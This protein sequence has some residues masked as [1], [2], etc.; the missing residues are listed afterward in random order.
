MIIHYSIA[1]ELGRQRQCQIAADVAAS[2]RYRAIRRR[3]WWA[4]TE[5][6]R[7]AA[8]DPIVSITAS[9]R[10]TAAVA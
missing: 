8:S 4:R 7:A 5:R 10:G 1:A 2:G 6:S 9:S 3:Y